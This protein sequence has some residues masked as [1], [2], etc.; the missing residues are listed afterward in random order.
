MAGMAR[1]IVQVDSA[2]IVA[3]SMAADRSDG[4]LGRRDA[5]RRPAIEIIHQYAFAI[6]LL[7]VMEIG[8]A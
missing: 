4:G 7:S 2:R 3:V 1:I 8:W 6:G 5:E